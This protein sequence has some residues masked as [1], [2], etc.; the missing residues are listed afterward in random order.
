MNE[1]EGY[2]DYHS[3]GNSTATHIC[4]AAFNNCCNMALQR[5][6]HEHRL[7]LSYQPHG[8]SEDP[9]GT[10]YDL[11][12]C[13]FSFAEPKAF[14]REKG[15]PPKSHIIRAR[16]SGGGVAGWSKGALGAGT[17]PVFAPRS[18]PS[19]ARGRAPG[20]PGAPQPVG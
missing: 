16:H 17:P 18:L 7:L 19:A 10:P 15:F 20:A 11:R 4:S 13:A 2:Y 14:C 5:Q 6:V 1:N 3:A 8:V 9:K 12:F